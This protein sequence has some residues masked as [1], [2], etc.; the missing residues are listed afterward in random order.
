MTGEPLAANSPQ[1]SVIIPARN[2][3]EALARTL[4]HLF[5]IAGMDA[6]E[7]IVAASGD[8]EG[9]ERAVG[10]RAQLL[11]PDGSSRAVLMNAGAARARSGVL[12]FL[13]ADSF[14]PSQAL[15]LI[16]QALSDQQ[17]GG[18]AFEQ[19]F[20]EPEWSLRVIT[21]VNRLRYRLTRNFYGDQGIFVRADVFRRM[22]GYGDLQLMEDLDFTQ[23]LKRLGRTALIRV[24]LRTS[25]R[26]FLTRGPWR[27]F[28]LIVWLL[29]L[30][31]LRLDTQRYAERWR[32]PADRPPGSPWSSRPHPESTGMA[33]EGDGYHEP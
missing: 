1:I 15:A 21:W 9:T 4:D 5:G 18:G 11:W 8:R 30:H 6:A 17:V 7:V 13:H 26:R 2:D 23:R 14:P 33:S 31:T 24:P 3:A 16:R 10:G 19:Q 29:L 32:G 28:S 25:G 27:T 20:I 22:G 12:F